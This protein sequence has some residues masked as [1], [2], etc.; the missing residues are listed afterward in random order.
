MLWC[1]RWLKPLCAG[2][3]LRCERV[4]G[5]CAHSNADASIRVLRS[6]YIKPVE[7]GRPVLAIR[8]RADYWHDQ[9]FGNEKG[10]VITRLI[11]EGPAFGR[12]V[13]AETNAPFGVASHARTTPGGTLWGDSDVVR[14]ALPG[15]KLEWRT[16]LGGGGGHSLTLKRF[17]AV[18]VFK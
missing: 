11:R 5:C 10:Q 2:C 16:I 14:L 1:A 18:V 8:S 12:R 9:G 3:G 13:V 4:L 15:D 17:R 7:I 6:D